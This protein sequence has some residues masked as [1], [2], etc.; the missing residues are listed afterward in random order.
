MKH[1]TDEQK[2]IWNK[3][4]SWLDADRLLL[5]TTNCFYYGAPTGKVV[6]DRLVPGVIWR[7]QKT[8][9][10]APEPTDEKLD[11]AINRLYGEG[12][13]SKPLR[14]LMQGDK[15][16]Q[17]QRPGWERYREYNDKNED[18][19]GAYIEYH[20]LVIKRI[21]ELTEPVLY[22]QR[23]DVQ[24]LAKEYQAGNKDMLPRIKNQLGGIIY[25]AQQQFS[26]TGNKEAFT[27]LAGKFSKR[28]PEPDTE[29]SENSPAGDTEEQRLMLT[30][31]P[32]KFNEKD[33]QAAVNQSLTAA[34][35]SYRPDQRAKFKT[36]FY[37]IFE[38]DLIDLYR[39][40]QH[41]WKHGHIIKSLEEYQ[42][43]L[44]HRLQ[45]DLITEYL[46]PEFIEQLNQAQ[47]EW[48][49]LFF[50]MLPDTLRHNV[51][52]E[53]LNNISTRT[54][55]RRR[56]SLQD[57]LLNNEQVFKKWERLIIKDKLARQPVKKQPAQSKEQALMLKHYK[58]FTNNKKPFSINPGEYEYKPG[59]CSGSSFF[60]LASAFIE[61]L[62]EGL[63]HFIPVPQVDERHMK[64][65][66]FYE[67]L[68]N[69]PVKRIDKKQAVRGISGKIIT[70]H[71]KRSYYY[72]GHLI[73]KKGKEVDQVIKQPELFC[74]CG[75]ILTVT[76]ECSNTVECPLLSNNLLYRVKNN[77]LILAGLI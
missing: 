5:V 25:R 2:R 76:G 15:S 37:K 62:E 39:E 50:K 21:R 61:P 49:N 28:I 45:G 30:T 41:G 64:R 74:K 44:Q 36:W 4:Y 66:K 70:R 48:I 54:E 32:F 65:V 34:L 52:A 63:Q 58:Q 3:Y 67:S 17:E 22:G 16:V 13:Y 29:Y 31:E 69:R 20:L 53:V 46:Q 43:E 19:L 56:K 7:D 60:P 59:I 24:V 1:L 18:P 35:D 14:F 11:K 9:R 33:L 72:S 51:T 42:D 55:H 77:R 73:S 27:N 47:C 8:H 57:L 10:Q 23:E 26:Y 75:I 71:F 6:G 38:N 68:K 40:Y 12:F